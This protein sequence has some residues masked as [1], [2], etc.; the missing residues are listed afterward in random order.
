MYFFC[1]S[2]FFYQGAESKAGEEESSD[3]NSEESEQ[4]MRR[5]RSRQRKDALAAV[6][7]PAENSCRTPLGSSQELPQLRWRK[8]RVGL[9]QQFE[10]HELVESSQTLPILGEKE[11]PQPCLRDRRDGLRGKGKKPIQ[12]QADQGENRKNYEKETHTKGLKEPI[13][14]PD[15][16]NSPTE[17]TSHNYHNACSIVTKN[18]PLT[19]DSLQLEVPLAVIHPG[20][21]LFLLSCKNGKV[22][23]DLE[24]LKKLFLYFAL[25]SFLVKL[26]PE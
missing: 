26:H 22:I 2:L 12:S 15:N 7:D 16:V 24:I 20:M 11:P 4:S 6:D 5:L 3:D 8:N 23:I 17:D 25:N 18:K 13:I 14:E 10:G 9:S 19:E 1:N 21:A